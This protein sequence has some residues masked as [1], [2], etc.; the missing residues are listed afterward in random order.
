MKD[1]PHIQDKEEFR[2]LHHEFILHID[3]S[4]FVHSEGTYVSVNIEF[5]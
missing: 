1:F 5:V 4:Q 3:L 2:P